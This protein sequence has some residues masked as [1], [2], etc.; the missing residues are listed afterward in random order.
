MFCRN[1]ELMVNITKEPIMTPDGLAVPP[2]QTAIRIFM[3]R[4]LLQVA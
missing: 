1:A 3:A 2:K 4:L